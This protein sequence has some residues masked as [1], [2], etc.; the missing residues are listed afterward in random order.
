MVNMR[1]EALRMT[2]NSMDGGFY[3]AKD[4]YNRIVNDYPE[5][6]CML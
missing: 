1:L 4:L 5:L 2:K 3:L 6:E